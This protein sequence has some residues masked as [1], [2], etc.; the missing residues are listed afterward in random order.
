VQQRLVERERERVEQ[1]ARIMLARLSDAG[2]QLLRRA[3]QTHLRG[4]R[5]DYRQAQ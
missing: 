3:A 4:V 1:D 2:H 5:E